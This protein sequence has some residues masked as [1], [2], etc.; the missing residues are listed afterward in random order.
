MLHGCMVGV[1]GR[2]GGSQGRGGVCGHGGGR[3]NETLR[4]ALFIAW[5]RSCCLLRRHMVS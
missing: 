2:L 3:H 5:G 1:L 4:L